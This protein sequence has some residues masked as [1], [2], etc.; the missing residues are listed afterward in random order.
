M[1]SEPQQLNLV[2]LRGQRCGPP[3]PTGVSHSQNDRQP[4]DRRK[5][6]GC[7]G[8]AGD[9]PARGAA[10]YPQGSSPGSQKPWLTFGHLGLLNSR[11]R[12]SAERGQRGNKRSR[13]RRKMPTFMPTEPP[14]ASRQRDRPYRSAGLP[15]REGEEQILMKLRFLKCL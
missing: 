13:E 10:W 4:G 14:C 3:P 15:F 2:N 1:G 5:T 7:Q 11:I 6:H 8:P 12:T 9:R